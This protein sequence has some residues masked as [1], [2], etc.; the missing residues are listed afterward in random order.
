MHEV[1]LG[2][3]ARDIGGDRQRVEDVDTRYDGISFKHILLPF[4]TAGFR[5]GGKTYQFVVNGR[6]GEVRGERPYS[7]VK[8]ALAVAVVIAL[9]AAAA[10]LFAG[11]QQMST[12]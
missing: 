8:I 12:Y 11:T 2:D 5:F 3:V 9:A 1:I 10:Y 6:T 7:I 4:W